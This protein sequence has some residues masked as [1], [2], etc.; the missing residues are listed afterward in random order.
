M[1]EDSQRCLQFCRIP[2]SYDKAGLR[3]PHKALE[4]VRVLCTAVGVISFVM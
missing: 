3:Q 4:A 1:D 2:V